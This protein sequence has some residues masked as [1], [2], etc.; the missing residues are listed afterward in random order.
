MTGML[1]D[2]KL[3]VLYVKCEVYP[4]ER[5]TLGQDS[6]GTYFWTPP[7]G[8]FIKRMAHPPGKKRHFSWV[9]QPYFKLNMW[10][11]VLYIY[12]MMLRMS[13]FLGSITVLEGTLISRSLGAFCSVH[14]HMQHTSTSFLVASIDMYNALFHVKFEDELCISVLRNKATLSKNWS[15]K[16]M[17]FGIDKVQIS[18]KPLLAFWCTSPTMRRYCLHITIVSVHIDPH[19]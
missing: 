7:L 10:K 2:R 12:R 18:K 9:K 3:N 1:I 14:R 17:N 16:P 6:V 4:F 5:T 8:N 15:S 13:N 11:G 19:E